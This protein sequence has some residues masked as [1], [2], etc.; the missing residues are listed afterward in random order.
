MRRLEQS[1]FARYFTKNIA[2]LRV[3]WSKIGNFA[4]QRVP[5]MNQCQRTLDFIVIAFEHMH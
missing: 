4:A 2:V 5:L 1:S 3:K